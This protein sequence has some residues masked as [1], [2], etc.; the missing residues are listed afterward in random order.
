[1]GGTALAEQKQNDVVR[2]ITAAW[3]QAQ[4][5]LVELRKQVEH[6]SALAMAKVQ[7]NFL[8]SDFDRALRDFGG[9]VW[10]QVKKGKLALPPSLSAA[11]RVMQEEQKRLDAHR[12]EISDLLREGAEV[13]SRIVKP[14][15]RGSNVSGKT[16]MAPKGKK[17]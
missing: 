4:T 1:M 8:E 11:A 2:Q 7:S 6:T 3:E 17:R 5:Q 15:H 10:E 14:G 9:A 12:A 13:A 16:L